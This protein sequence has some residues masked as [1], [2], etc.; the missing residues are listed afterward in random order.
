MDGFATP[1]VPELLTPADRYIV[2]AN[3]RPTGI[4]FRSSVLITAPMVVDVVSTTRAAPVTCTTSD[5]P[6]TSSFRST[7]ATPP[8]RTDTSFCSMA[9]KPESSPRTE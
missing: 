5:T 1:S 4:D 3:V 6:P 2:E 7:S 8:T 9:L